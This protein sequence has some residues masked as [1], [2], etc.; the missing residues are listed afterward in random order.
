MCDKFFHYSIRTK[1]TTTSTKWAHIEWQEFEYESPTKEAL[2][3]EKKFA[4]FANHAVI[5]Y[6]TSFNAHKNVLAKKLPHI[7]CN[8][9]FFSSFYLKKKRTTLIEDIIHTLT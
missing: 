4:T 2:G 9:L 6:S 1:C 3:T 7:F 5:F 8:T